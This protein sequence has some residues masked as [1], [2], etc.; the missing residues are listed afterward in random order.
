MG[1]SGRSPS[2][3]TR[4]LGGLLLLVGCDSGSSPPVTT[5]GSTGDLTAELARAFCARQACCGG[6]GD[7]SAPTDAGADAGSASG[8]ACAADAGTSAGGSGGAAGSSSCQDRAAVSIAE[9]LALV[10]T[11]SQEGLLAINSTTATTCVAAY[12]NRACGVESAT[13]DVQDAVG[14][15]SGLFTGFIPLYER[16][17]MTPECA[18]GSFCLSQ[19]TGQNVTSLSGSP[20]LG[21]CYPYQELGNACNTSSDCDPTNAPVCDPLTLTCQ[22]S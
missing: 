9:Q 10:T 3:L 14:A 22:T 1:L 7:A 13:P 16:C 11:A 2:A 4:L 8:P 20:S 18:A 5:I 6:T 17:D 21:T 15:C 12:Q 19:G